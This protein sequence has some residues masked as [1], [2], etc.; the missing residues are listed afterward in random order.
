MMK[1]YQYGNP[2][3]MTVLIQLVDDHDLAVIENE[4]A[5]IQRLTNAD[6]HLL[7]IKVNNW[8]KDLSPWEAPAVFGSEPFGSGAADTLA[9]VLQYTTDQNKTYLIGGYS[10]SGLFALWAAYQTDVFKGVAAASPSIWFPQ[11]TDYMREHRILSRCVYL[12]LGD[13]EPK[14]RNQIMSAVGEKI[15]EAYDILNNQGVNS[16]LEWNQGNH[17]KEPDLRTARAFAWLI[18]AIDT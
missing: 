10:L 9:E 4:I 14:T 15:Q 12:S 6:F 18:K 5:E 7:A 16:T 13:K 3:A 1:R 17:F 8:N 2:N 11:F